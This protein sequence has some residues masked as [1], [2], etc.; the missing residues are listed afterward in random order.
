M[1]YPKVKFLYA[2]VLALATLIPVFLLWKNTLLLLIILVAVSSLMLSL[3]FN[4]VTILLFFTGF[5]FGPL[6][7]AVAIYAGAWNYAY[8]NVFGFPLWLPF[9]WGNAALFFRRVAAYLEN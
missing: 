9:V 8:P 2:C 6:S 4:K 3:E 7:E 5:V 1:T